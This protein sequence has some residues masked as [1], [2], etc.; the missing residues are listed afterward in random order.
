MKIAVDAMG[1]DYAPAVVVEGAVWAA[2]EFDV[3]IIL[4][5]DK[6]RIEDEL[7][8]HDRQGL[9]ISVLHTSQVVGMEESIDRI[10]HVIARK[11]KNNPLLIGEPGIGKTAAVA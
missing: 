10:I 9:P 1:G 4:V 5:G 7:K 8:K 3:P 6:A 11:Q 2:R